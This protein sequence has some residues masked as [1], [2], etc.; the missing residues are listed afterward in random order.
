[1]SHWHQTD[2]ANCSPIEWDLLFPTQKT[3][4]KK[5][6]IKSIGKERKRKR[7]QERID[8]NNDSLKKRMM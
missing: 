7:K 8:R 5:N 1:M 6:Q 2:K 4:T 3:K